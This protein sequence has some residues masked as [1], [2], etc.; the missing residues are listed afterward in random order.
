V[1]GRGVFNHPMGPKAGAASLRQGW[2]AFK[3]G[4]TLEEYARHH[5]ELRAAMEAFGS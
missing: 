4:L 5:P 1:P 2:E 3:K